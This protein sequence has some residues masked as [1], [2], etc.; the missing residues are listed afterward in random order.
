MREYIIYAIL[1]FLPLGFF[2]AY[3]LNKQGFNKKQIICFTIAALAA[4][5]LFPISAARMGTTPTGIIFV[6]ILALL[7]WQIMKAEQSAKDEEVGEHPEATQ[8]ELLTPYANI[9]TDLV[10]AETAATSETDT[11][12]SEGLQIPD[13]DKPE[14]DMIQF[15][16]SATDED[17]CVPEGELSAIVDNMENGYSPTGIGNE[18]SEQMADSEDKGMEQKDPEDYMAEDDE[19]ALEAEIDDSAPDQDSV[20]IADEFNQEE[21]HE[22]PPSETESL[23]DTEG[24]NE[25]ENDTAVEVINEIDGKDN[26]PAIN[27]MIDAGF[28]NKINGNVPETVRCFEAA[29]QQT[30][31]ADLKYLLSQELVLHYEILGQ[32]TNAI[33]TINNTIGSGLVPTAGLNQAQ[34]KLE[35]LQRMVEELERLGMGEVPVSEVPRLVKIK[36]GQIT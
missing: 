8:P 22:E 29:F 20:I 7:S 11:T 27:R 6:F 15:I 23:P 24:G 14:T 18:I 30:D 3:F 9:P 32:Y 16:R 36:V 33:N 1:I 10:L 21:I 31:S 12:V 35:Y 26:T 17:A 2:M 5:I 25:K 19:T 34:H 13:Q 4:V 28:E